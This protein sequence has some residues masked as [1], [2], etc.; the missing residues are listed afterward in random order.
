MQS[1]ARRL[2][3]RRLTEARRRLPRL[4]AHA[5]RRARRF[6]LGEAR[7]AALLIQ[8][9]ARRSA[10]LKAFGVA[11]R[12]ATRLA[13][14]NRGFMARR[15]VRKLLAERRAAAAVAVQRVTRR[16]AAQNRFAR[17]RRAAV[18]VQAAATASCG[19]ELLRGDARRRGAVAARGRGALSRRRYVALLKAACVA[20]LWPGGGPRSRRRRRGGAGATLRRSF[21]VWCAAGRGKCGS[22]A[23]ARPRSVWRRS[24][25]VGSGGGRRSGS[26]RRLPSRR[27]GAAP[28]YVSGIAGPSVRRCVSS[29]ASAVF[30]ARRRYAEAKGA[31]VALETMARRHLAATS[32]GNLRVAAAVAQKRARAASAKREAARRRRRRVEALRTQGAV[33]LETTVR[34]HLAATSYRKLRVGVVVAQKRARC[35]RCQTGGGETAPPAR[36]GFAGGRGGRG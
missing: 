5:R 32:Y 6:D 35:H 4:Q 18:V 15:R 28:W 34:R 16:A 27:P 21:R 2:P 11:K 36:Y 22:R 30:Q 31:A 19:S 23:R 13:A 7:R 3:P 8:A 25:A 26:A 17:T 14:Q 12:G 10:A 9:A 20:Q 29:A 1:I 33:A 24:R